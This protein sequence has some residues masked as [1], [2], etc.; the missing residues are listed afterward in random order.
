[1]GFVLMTHLKR[2]QLEGIISGPLSTALLHKS[3]S[4]TTVPETIGAVWA[5]ANWNLVYSKNRG[6]KQPQMVYYSRNR[7]STSTSLSSLF[8]F[9]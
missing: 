3:K 9:V 2:A 4:W 8:V 6:Y 7:S 5:M 1:M